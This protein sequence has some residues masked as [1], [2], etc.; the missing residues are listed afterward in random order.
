MTKPVKK[1]GDPTV[2]EGDVVDFGHGITAEVKSQDDINESVDKGE[3]FYAVM[4]KALCS[5]DCIVP[6]SHTVECC[7]CKCDC[8]MSPATYKTWQSSDG[9]IICIQCAANKIEEESDA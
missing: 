8:W 3:M 9:P 4:P 6:G 1:I 7:E 5:T 2:K